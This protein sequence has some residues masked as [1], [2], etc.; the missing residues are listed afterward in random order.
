MNVHPL[1]IEKNF[2][3]IEINTTGLL[4]L[5]DLQGGQEGDTD[6]NPA[7]LL[8]PTSSSV[9]MLWHTSGASFGGAPFELNELRGQEA[10]I[11][12]SIKKYKVN[13]GRIFFPVLI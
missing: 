2:M 8:E 5:L 9:R 11:K 10:N 7:D 1:Y 13:Q 3:N 4:P 6:V 12:A